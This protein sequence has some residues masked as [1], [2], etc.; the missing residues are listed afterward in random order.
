MRIRSV[1]AWS[2]DLALAEPYEI[3]YE[4]I[5]TAPQVFVRLTTDSLV[6]YGCAAP[7]MEVTGEDANTV[8]RFLS[9]IAEPVLRGADGLA[10]GAHPGAA[11]RAGA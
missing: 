3:A 5:S 8:L 4:T 10:S 6:A 11:S 9:E 7:D 2:V 1:E